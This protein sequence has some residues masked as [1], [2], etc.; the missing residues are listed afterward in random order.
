MIPVLE[1]SRLDELAALVALE[2]SRPKGMA[3]Y[4]VA[5]YA[6]EMASA[7]AVIDAGLIAVE[8]EAIERARADLDRWLSEGKDIRSMRADAPL[9]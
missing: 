2:R 3:A 8:A 5:Q 1:T 7:I 9:Q 6:Q 4:R